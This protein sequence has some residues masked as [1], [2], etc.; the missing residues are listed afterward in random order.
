MSQSGVYDRTTSMPDIETLT[1]NVGGAVG[2]TGGNINVVGAGAILVTGNPGTST[3]TITSTG[4]GF[5]WNEV[6]VTGP[7]AM[8]VNNGYIA[9]NG[10]TVQL[11]LPAVAVIGD[12]IRVTGKGAGGWQIQQNAGQTIYFASQATTTGA[13]GSLSS[14]D[15]RDS[16]ELVCVT[17]NND[18]NVL[19]SIGNITVV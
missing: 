14:T 12:M 9:N 11:T 7:T 2:P 18:W 8:A 1:G 19:S 10:A 4:G 13:G 16:I 15:D 5:T 6:I 3:L 17:A